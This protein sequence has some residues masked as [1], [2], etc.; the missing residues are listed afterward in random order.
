MIIQFTNGENVEKEWGILEFQ[1]DIIA[2]NVLNG[3]NL[4]DIKVTEVK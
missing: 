2:N 3:C 1:G 4:G